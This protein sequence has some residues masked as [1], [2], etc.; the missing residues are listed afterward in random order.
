VPHYLSATAFPAAAL[1][2]I[3]GLET[4]AGV[5]VDTLSLRAAA[6]AGRQKVDQLIG[7]SREHATLIETLEAQIDEAEGTSLGR[8][9]E[10][11]GRLPSGD[12]LA[13]ELE[14]FLRDDTDSEQ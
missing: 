2:L 1:A 3:E 14:K 10:S 4:V 8:L 12:E 7:Q 5:S 9:D 6:E 13:A 11:G